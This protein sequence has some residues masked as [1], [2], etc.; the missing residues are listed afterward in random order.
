MSAFRPDLTADAQKP[1]LVRRL[2]PVNNGNEGQFDIKLAI[3]QDLEMETN[4]LSASSL[5]LKLDR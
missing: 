3:A 1:G 2:W 5:C 4:K